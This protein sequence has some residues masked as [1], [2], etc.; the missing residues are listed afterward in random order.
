LRKIFKKGNILVRQGDNKNKN[1]YILR[2]GRCS[3]TRSANNS[4]L[5]CGKIY[6]GDIFG[7]LSMILGL[8]RSA[9]ILAIDDEVEVEELSKSSFLEIIR[10]DP[11]I[12]WTVLTKLAIKTQMLDE[13]RNEMMQPEVL[14][15]LIEAKKKNI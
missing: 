15:T 6:P 11:E 8:E 5:D 13:V 2:K 14:R 10:E 12:A 3:I 7:E 4:V 1:L 9:T